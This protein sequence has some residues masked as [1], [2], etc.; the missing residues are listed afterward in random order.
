MPNIVYV[1]TN[2]AMPGIVKIGM[3]EK[4]D[5]Q[6]R[7]RDLY[8]TGVPLPF[9]CVI[10]RQIEDREAAK[11]ESALHTAFDP[12]R[13]NP[14]REFF[15]IEPEQVEALLLVMPGHDV[16]PRVSK[17]IAELQPED[18][19]AASE[20]KRRQTRTNELEFLESLNENVI[21][22]YERVLALGKQ[23]GMHINWGKKGFSLNVVSNGT[24]VVVCYGFPP[25][26]DISTDFALI[27]R[28]TNLPQE[29]IE[30]LRK[31]ALDTR[32]F[33]HMGKHLE[34]SCRT[35]QKLEEPQLDALIGWL[36]AVVARIREFESVNSDE[37]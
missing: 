26:L 23:E 35:D 33:V 19:E 36:E 18:I 34:L 7:M 16:T 11:V 14:S 25:S 15:Q 12:S 30:T 10:A 21:R 31:Q 27:S 1:L 4:D 37:S 29:A 3:T 9:E 20:Y 5:V 28:K 2:P 17:Q 13:I 8:S 24:K 32:L 22:V 6:L